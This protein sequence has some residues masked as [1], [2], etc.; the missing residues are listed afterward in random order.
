MSKDSP[1]GSQRIFPMLAYEDAGAAIDW[2]VR[3]FG[4]RELTRMA[5]EDGRIGHAE[6]ELNGGVVYLASP[7]TDYQSP[8]RHRE[9]CEPARKWSAVPWVI[10]GV[11]GEVDDA[12]AH[13]NRAK[14]AGATILS[15]PEDQSFG[16]IYRAEDI[17]GHRWMFIQPSSR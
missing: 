16:R 7:T 14:A 13:Y 4:F 3:A 15:E 1:N 11:M 9:S 6:L 5:G 2:L 17:E 8:R 10:D 12:D